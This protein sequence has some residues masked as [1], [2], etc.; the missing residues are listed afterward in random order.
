MATGAGVPAKRGSGGCSEMTMSLN[1]MSA[2]TL[3]VRNAT[4]IVWLNT[5]CTM[6]QWPS[7]TL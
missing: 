6:T 1:V 2:T 5:P 3:Y 4:C 7:M